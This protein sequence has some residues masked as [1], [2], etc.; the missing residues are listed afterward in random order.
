MD[1]I[2]F[3]NTQEVLKAH[4]L[5]EG[6]IISDSMSPLIMVGDKIR[7]EPLPSTLSQF[8]IVVFYDGVRLVCHYVTSVNWIKNAKGEIIIN[9]RGLR[10]PFL[11][12][13]IT[14]SSVLGIVT[15]HKI[16]FWTR[17]KLRLFKS[18]RG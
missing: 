3:K 11:D 16:P 7:I 9:T 5:V 13:P 4:G 6:K 2:E 15:S 17:L 1:K 12:L 8:D 14:V 10:N 18:F